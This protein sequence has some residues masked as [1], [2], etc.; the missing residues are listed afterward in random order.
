MLVLT[1]GIVG[2]YKILTSGRSLATTTENRIKAVN[3]ARE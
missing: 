1:T 2:A 3:I